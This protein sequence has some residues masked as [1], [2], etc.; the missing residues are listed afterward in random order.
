MVLYVFES[1]HPKQNNRRVFFL[2][3]YKHLISYQSGGGAI[4]LPFV[5][6]NWDM[7]ALVASIFGNIWC[8]L[9]LWIIHL[10]T[11]LDGRGTDSLSFISLDKML[12][13]SNGWIGFKSIFLV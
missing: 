12:D 4:A 6:M 7:F 8:L 1:N 9:W 2:T 13:G 5:Q 10:S 11:W 3:S